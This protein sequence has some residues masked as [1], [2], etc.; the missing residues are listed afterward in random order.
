MPFSAGVQSV[1]LSQL[2]SFVVRLEG[3]DWTTTEVVRTLHGVGG[4][5]ILEVRS[6]DAAEELAI[7]GKPVAVAAA[8]RL[9]AVEPSDRIRVLSRL[10]SE[11]GINLVG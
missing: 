9:L 6:S 4:L 11:F 7:A 1:D 2:V 5:E 10:H 3:S 8:V